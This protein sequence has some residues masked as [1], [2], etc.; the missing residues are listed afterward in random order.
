MGRSAAALMLMALIVNS[1]AA[2]GACRAESRA[3]LVPLVE[4]YTSEGCS[5]CPPADAWLSANFAP[6]SHGAAVALAFHV[7]YWD[8]LGWKDRFASPAYTDR[9]YRAMRANRATFVFTPQVLVQGRDFSDWRRG[10]PARA[11]KAAAMQPPRATITL[12][13]RSD[14]G[15]YDVE[16]S[17]V[18]PQAPH[19][20]VVL[21][22]AYV[23]NGLRS[24]VKAGENR[25]VVLTH[26]HVVRAFETRRLA[27][28]RSTSRM[29]IARPREA[30]TAPLLVAFVQD[31]ANGDVLQTLALAPDDCR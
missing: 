14:R 22:V 8:R 26:D 30:G 1:S 28:A 9:Q 19:G 24:D 17:V 3:E 16:A 10:S 15:E 12:A 23:D 31:A 6:G 4:L 25:G 21:A 13:A 29:R 18:L 2:M 11:L 20:D 27:E 5:S 7:D